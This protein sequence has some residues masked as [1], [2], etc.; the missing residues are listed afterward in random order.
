MRSLLA[1]SF[2]VAAAA[3]LAACAT[4]AAPS[5]ESGSPA[6][7]DPTSRID[8]ATTDAILGEAFEDRAE[9]VQV[10][11]RGIVVRVLEDDEDGSPHQRFVVRLA[12]GQTLLIA[13]NLE[14]AR[15]VR[16]LRVRDQV[17]FYGEYEWNSEGG[18]IHWTHDDPQGEHVAGWL[19]HRGRVYQ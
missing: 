10:L 9:H 8:V 3:G 17:S 19:Y 1:A 12:S 4:A 14:L 16:R 15:R 6:D 13:H 2:A 18:T 11:G 5:D 7:L